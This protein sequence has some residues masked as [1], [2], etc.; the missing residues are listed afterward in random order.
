MSDYRRMGHRG[1]PAEAFRSEARTVFAFLVEE[2]GFS[3]S[4]V[5][6]HGLLFHR[7]GLHIEVRFL[8]GHEP[9]VVT[10]IVR[11]APD[12]ESSRGSLECLYVAGGCGPAQD[13][14]G[15]APTRR[16]MLKRVHQHGIAVRML[17]PQLLP[18]EIEQFL[19]RCKG[20]RSLPAA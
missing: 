7:A 19:V 13:V 18:P 20:G 4:E 9:E 11:D 10:T 14:P 1:D 5:T 3:S 6:K 17:L 12:G 8:D 16:A 2:A 15:S